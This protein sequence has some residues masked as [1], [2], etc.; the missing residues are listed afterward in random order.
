MWIYQNFY[1]YKKLT[2]CSLSTNLVSAINLYRLFFIGKANNES[3]DFLMTIAIACVWS[4]HDCMCRVL[5]TKSFLCV[6][7]LT[8][9]RA[10]IDTFTH[11]CWYENDS[12]HFLCKVLCIEIV[13]IQIFFQKVYLVGSAHSK[14]VRSDN[15]ASIIHEYK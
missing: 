15:I 7:L 13:L 8:I 10:L 9:F 5:T 2:D 12:I 1:V 14:R 6:E 3:S 4:M 11:S